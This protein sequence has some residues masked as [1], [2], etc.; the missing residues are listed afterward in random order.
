MSKLR[1]LSICMMVLSLTLSFMQR[2]WL[3]WRS[4]LVLVVTVE[5]EILSITADYLV[6]V[7]HV[8]EKKD[9]DV[10]VLN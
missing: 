2:L 1:L 4:P 3:Q 8:A 7:V 5:G 10:M 6:R 9:A